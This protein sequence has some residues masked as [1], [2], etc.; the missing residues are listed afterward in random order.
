MRWHTSAA[1]AASVLLLSGAGLVGAAEVYSWR[2]ADGRVH[3]GDRKPA[4]TAA[5]RIDLPTVNSV[6]AV[7]VEPTAM[8]SR[9]VTL[10][11]A[12]WCGYCRK[13]RAHFKREAIPFDEFDVET[14]A[15]GRADYARLQGRGVP[16]IL[17]GQQRMNGFDPDRFAALYER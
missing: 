16:I 15:K 3:F 17:V 9:K 7:S 1:R 11:S 14:S 4:D 8:S 6:G 2:D 13:A 12:V 10:Y 5:R